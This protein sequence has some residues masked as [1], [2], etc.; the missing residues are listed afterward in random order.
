MGS[1]ES[2]CPEAKLAVVCAGTRDT[3][4]HGQGSLEFPVKGCNLLVVSVLK[5]PLL[6]VTYKKGN[7][8]RT[9][10]LK[11]LA[12]RNVRSSLG[13]N[14]LDP[15]EFKML[16]QVGPRQK[17]MDKQRRPLVK[18]RFLGVCC[19]W[20]KKHKQPVLP[21]TTKRH[22]QNRSFVHACPFGR[23]MLYQVSLS[24][25]MEYDWHSVQLDSLKL[26]VWG[27]SRLCSQSLPRAL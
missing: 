7:G 12:F 15:V 4:S 2:D 9:P 25:F 21:Q 23:S 8:G 16:K 13:L 17:R 3:L 11:C 10:S 1:L 27:I 20:V 19:A 5:L 22:H 26:K 6:E 18:I 14:W 24:M